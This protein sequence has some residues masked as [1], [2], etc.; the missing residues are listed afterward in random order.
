MEKLTK[1][2]NPC[3]TCCFGCILHSYDLGKENINMVCM[4]L[5]IRLDMEG[6]QKHRFGDV[7]KVNKYL[8]GAF[9]SKKPILNSLLTNAFCTKHSK[10]N[11]L[12][13]SNR[14]NNTEWNG[15]E[16]FIDMFLEPNEINNTQKYTIS[17]CVVKNRISSEKNKTEL[18]QY[19]YWTFCKIHFLSMIIFF[20]FFLSSRF[21]C[22]H[23]RCHSLPNTSHSHKTWNA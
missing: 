9:A 2:Y 8:C 1:A 12:C 22:F 4:R 18:P 21:L 16:C 11:I 5:H 13:G 7:F 20:W 17:I 23:S 6:V 10:R 15:L 14:N 3:Y 19:Y